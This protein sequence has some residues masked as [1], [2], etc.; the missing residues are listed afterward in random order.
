LT[1]HVVAQHFTSVAW[2]ESLA[3]VTAH[4]V[5]L[6]ATFVQ[7]SLPV[8]TTV[9]L[10]ASRLSTS[11]HACGPLHV[12]LHDVAPPLHVTFRQAA[13][14]VHVTRQSAPEGQR[15]SSLQPGLPGHAKTH[16]SPSHVP[17]IVL[18]ADVS[19][20]LGAPVSP[21]L[22]LL[23]EAPLLVLLEDDDD[24]LPL[25]PASVAGA[26]ASAASKVGLS[27]QPANKTTTAMDRPKR[28][29]IFGLSHAGP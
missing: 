2:H 18:Q 13:C 23:D 7:A 4:V 24:E 19:Q 26:A 6:Q 15:T 20:R 8:Q 22:L 25:V 5:P 17:P 12:R 11:L 29:R 3:H 10:G 21:L 16:A 27:T 9:E 1:V 28:R 14:P